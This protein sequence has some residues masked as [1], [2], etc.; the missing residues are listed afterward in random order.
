MAVTALPTGRE[1]APATLSEN[2]RPEWLKLNVKCQFDV[3]VSSRK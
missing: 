3:A 1:N 2:A